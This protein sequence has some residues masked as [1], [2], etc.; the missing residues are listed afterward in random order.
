MSCAALLAA[1]SL[2]GACS[3]TPEPTPGSTAPV[4]TTPAPSTSAPSP[5]VTTP[6]P[7]ASGIPAAAKVKSKAGAEAFARFYIDLINPAWMTPDPSLLE[8]FSSSSCASCLD[9]IRTATDLK[10]KGQRYDSKVVEIPAVTAVDI[11]GDTAKVKFTLRQLRSSV[12]DPS[13]A[14]VLTDPLQDFIR[15]L[16]L[17]WEGGKWSVT[18]LGEPPS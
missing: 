3:S 4:V 13:G 2:V 5:T 15:R 16:E 10:S 11:Q 9:L 6:S 1:V 7:S 14:V 8:P 17:Q 12:V 18:D